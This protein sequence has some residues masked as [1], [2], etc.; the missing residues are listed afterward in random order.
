MVNPYSLVP[1]C[2]AAPSVCH[3][4][5]LPTQPSARQEY[6]IGMISPYSL[7]PHCCAAPSGCHTQE[8]PTQPSARQEYPRYDK[9]QLPCFLTVV[10]P[11]YGSIPKSFPHNSSKSKKFG[12]KDKKEQ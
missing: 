6:P 10:Q 2:S 12:E 9:S 8:F 7:V 3:T 11:L 4:Q 5:E 1:H